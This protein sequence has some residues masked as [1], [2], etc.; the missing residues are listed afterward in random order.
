MLVTQTYVERLGNRHEPL[1]VAVAV[2]A[3]RMFDSTALFHTYFLASFYKQ[4]SAGLE[5]CRDV[6]LR[7][8]KT[9]CQ[10]HLNM[11]AVPSYPSFTKISGKVSK[12]T[13]ASVQKQF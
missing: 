8:S 7:K 5:W 11:V 9:P 12:S 10:A 6:A 4:C 13:M 2:S 1:M 3:A